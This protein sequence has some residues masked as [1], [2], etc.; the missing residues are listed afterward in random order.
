M[1]IA[2]YSA[3]TAAITVELSGTGAPTMVVQHG[4]GT[5]TLTAADGLLGSAF[6]DS[7]TVGA[8]DGSAADGVLS[9]DLGGGEDSLLLS[10]SSTVRVDGEGG[11]IALGG[12]GFGFANVE[13]IAA[14]AGSVIVYGGNA[15]GH[16]VGGSAVNYLEGS[17]PGTILES[18]SGDSWFVA[19]GG[20]T[21]VSGA[22]DDLIQAEGASPVTIVF[23]RGSGHDLLG[24]HFSGA[25]LWPADPGGLPWLE[26]RDLLR[27]RLG[28]TILLDGLSAADI[29]LVWE[30][31][32]HQAPLYVLG[33]DDPVDIR[34]GPA[35]IRIL[36]TGE[37]LHLGTLAGAWIGGDFCIVLIGYSEWDLV[38]DFRDG[39]GLGFEEFSAD[40]DLFSFGTSSRYSLLDLF[41]PETLVSTAL[42]P[43]WS[44]AAG[45]PD[46]LGSEAGAIVGTPW[47]DYILTGTAGSDDMFGG[48]G[49]D[50]FDDGDGDDF[51]RGGYGMDVFVA[52]AGDDDLD[53]GD[54]EDMVSYDSATAPVNVD[55]QAGTASSSQFGTDRLGSIEQVSGGSGDDV[56]A[57]TAGANRLAGGSGDDLLVGRGGDDN[58][59]YNRTFVDGIGYVGDYGDDVIEDSGGYDRLELTWHS[60]DEVTASLAPDN[61]YLLSFAGGGSVTILGG[62]L[63]ANAIDEVVFA[64][65][66][67]WTGEILSAMA[68]PVLETFG[69]SGPDS[70]AGTEGRRN[71]LAGLGG[72]DA[73]EGKGGPDI[74]EGG[75]GDDSLVGL[76]G[77]DSLEGGSGDDAL[78]G[79]RGADTLSGG[80]GADLIVGGQEGDLLTGGAG[81][82]VFRFGYAEGGHGA[83]ADRIADF[84]PGVDKIDFGEMDG[85][86]GQAGRQAFI[87]IGSAAFSGTSGEVR[88]E[89]RNGDTWV[90]VDGWGSGYASFEIA[91]TGTVA[92]TAADFIL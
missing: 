39:E 22:G 4:G 17:G 27:D 71:R 58:Y 82:D 60:V 81:A 48:Y 31:E 23:G 25:I 90:L 88:I 32:A 53:G 91:M 76:H 57:G 72:D 45:L 83:R 77:D 73:L 9:V 24:S 84:A 68:N 46:R 50:F 59:V 28:D 8:L 5:D 13:T 78:Y 10:T 29:E 66:D 74:L 2:D 1:P 43:A 3:A 79:G 65:G 70:L 21:V 15:A 14:G 86:F 75:D 12:G 34:I 33:F 37:T 85:D 18:T 7:L 49:D 54:G 61:S 35:A 20:A 26:Q 64:G 55:L 52:G 40:Y 62:A 47:S 92:V 44:S 63:A 67:W 51:V 87:F 30:W 16:Y 42:D 6:D 89:T 69:T 41:E 11:R 56:L 19:R 38:L 36:D 80:D